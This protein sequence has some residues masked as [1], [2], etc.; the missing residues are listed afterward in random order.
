[1]KNKL[2]RT[3]GL[4]IIFITFST[5]VN[6]MPAHA[7][8]KIVPSDDGNTL[9]IHN[10]TAGEVLQGYTEEL[11]LNNIEN[12]VVIGKMNKSDFM[13][14][15]LVTHN[16]KLIDLYNT[17]IDNIPAGSFR[18]NLKLEKFVLP[19]SLISIEALAFADCDNLEIEKLPESLEYIGDYAFEYCEKLNLTI[20]QKVRL[21]KGA[22]NYCHNVHFLEYD[23]TIN[24]N[25][26]TTSKTVFSSI[27]SYIYSWF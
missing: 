4:L 11:I 2:L 7:S 10:E 17:E 16:C 23:K 3:F 27:V 20:P 8:W 1:M 14:L 13:N 6:C 22:F 12:V 15:R 24:S 26:N 9:T 5:G 25:E 21:G 18:K 19:K